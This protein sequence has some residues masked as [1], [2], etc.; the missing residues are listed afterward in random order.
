MP[1]WLDQMLSP[2]LI[3]HVR[4]QLNMKG[5]W[6][7]IVSKISSTIKLRPRKGD[8]VVISLAQLAGALDMPQGM[9]FS[10]EEG[11]LRLLGYR[12]GKGGLSTPERRKVL[13]MIYKLPLASLPRVANWQEWGEAKSS[14]RLGK[15]QRCLI[16][17]AEQASRRRTPPRE[18][19]EAW[20]AD[21]SWISEAFS[22][23]V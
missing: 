10:P 15:M 2:S 9:E 7:T 11:V 12:V 4:P 22:P 5:G 18:A 6:Y 17:F 13:G 8:S 23:V 20:N 21:E 14:A 19:V 3:V 16:A 1:E